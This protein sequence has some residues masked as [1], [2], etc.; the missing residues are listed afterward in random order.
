MP[1][2]LQTP[3]LR[4]PAPRP[5]IT[6]EVLADVTR[7]IVECA[8]PFAVIL[9]GSYAW[10]KPHED[11]DIDLLVITGPLSGQP[12]NVSEIHRAASIPR[13]DRDVIIYTPEQ[14]ATRIAMDD[15]FILRI[16]NKGRVLYERAK[17]WETM[18]V[19]PTMT[20]VEEWIVKA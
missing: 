16:L 9:F 4:P 11:S 10:G 18:E 17:P 1:A 6:D 5:A 12:D 13:V 19:H 14:V 8:H 2:T 7:R 20:L 3:A 15:Y